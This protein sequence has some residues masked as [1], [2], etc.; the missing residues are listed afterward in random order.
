MTTRKPV[1]FA[2][3]NGDMTGILT[4]GVKG[5]NVMGEPLYPVTAE[6]DAVSDKTR[7]GFSFIAPG[8][9]EQS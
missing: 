2:T 8:P 5:P 1:R 9:E 6:Y 7:V 4:E 3:Y